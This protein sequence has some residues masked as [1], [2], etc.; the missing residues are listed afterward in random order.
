M[1]Y[2]A[3]ALSKSF[4]R[5]EG[6]LLHL[7]FSAQISKNNPDLPFALRL[8]PLCL[9]PKNLFRPTGKT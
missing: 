8:N 6:Y 2:M 5:I 9:K 3:L 4:K 1:I 7:I